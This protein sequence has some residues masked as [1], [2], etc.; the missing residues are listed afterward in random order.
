LPDPASDATPPTP[1]PPGDH[2]PS[3]AGAAGSG[4]FE[5]AG[6]IFFALRALPPA[7]RDHALA[8]LTAN[9][10]QLK[11]LVLLL[12]KGA[13][14]PLAVESLADD[15]RA[16]ADANAAATSGAPET[17][18]P[19]PGETAGDRI[20]PYRLLERLGEGGFGIVFAAEQL[21]PVRR[22]VAL[23]V[24]KLGM[25]TRQVVARFEAERQA[26]ALMDH[27]NIARVFDAGATPTGRP[28][29]A[30]ELVRGEPI[31]TFCDRE[32]L[33]LN[34][35]LAL[36]AA[37]CDAVQ[38][39]HAKGVIHRDIKPSNVLVS[40]SA[41]TPTPKVIDFGIAKATD[42]PLTEKTLFTEHRQLV[43]TPE[44]MS[45]EQAEGTR[46]IDTRTDVYALGVLLYELVT[47]VTPFDGRALRS[48]GYGEMQRIIREV[49]PPRPSTR[50]SQ[51]D[52]E[53]AA[54]AA[55]LRGTIPNRLRTLVKRELDWV[56]MKA[57]EKERARRYDSASNLA[58]DVRRHLAG[59][60]VLAVPPSPTYLLR[61]FVRRNKG[62]VAAAALLA[63]SLLAGLVGTA[64]GLVTA[65]AQRTEALIQR[66]RADDNATAAATERDHAQWLAYRANIAAALSALELGDR[67]RAASRLNACPQR[68]RG[69]EWRYA[70]ARLDLSTTLA[71]GIFAGLR[72]T[73]LEL[74]PDGA[75]L[76]VPHRDQGRNSF[77]VRLL[78]A[79]S[80]GPLVTIIGHAAAVSS[81]RFSPDGSRILTA[82]YDQT[83]RQWDAASGAPIGPVISTP[84]PVTSACWNADTSR[85]LIVA[86]HG[87]LLLADSATGS[88]IA[89]SHG[90]VAYSAEFLNEGRAIVTRGFFPPLVWDLNLHPIPHDLSVF[91]GTTRQSRYALPTRSGRAFA[92]ISPGEV[93]RIHRTDTGI[94]TAAMRGHWTG[95]DTLAFSRDDTILASGSQDNTLRTWDALSGDPLRTLLGHKGTVLAAA[96]SLDAARVFSIG[97]DGTLRAWRTDRTADGELITSP[98]GRQFTDLAYSPTSPLL[99]ITTGYA[100]TTLYSTLTHAPARQLGREPDAALRARFSSDGARLAQAHPD[101]SLS[102]WDPH[103]G[104]R[105]L[106]IPTLNDTCT[107]FAL[108]PDASRIAV[109]LWNGDVL[110]LN[111]RSGERVATLRRGGDYA[112]GLDF[113]SDSTTLFVAT[114]NQPLARFNAETGAPLAPLS[115]IDGGLNSLTNLGRGLGAANYHGELTVIFRLD[116]GE[117]LTTLRGHGHSVRAAAMHP[118]GSRV[119]TASFDGT[120]RVWDTSTGDEV[121]V[122]RTDRPYANGIS[123]SPDGATVG[124]VFEDA[125]AQFFHTRRFNPEN[126]STTTTPPPPGTP[127]ITGTPQSTPQ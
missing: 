117:T 53:P 28:Y 106:S 5:R 57:L 124:I 56:I 121:A 85:I 74:S 70:H 125:N 18:S 116:T 102:V 95:I 6:E 66:N 101:G 50:I 30:M 119:F 81:A 11:D 97:A 26:L 10:P 99:A 41:N 89:Q 25:D 40:L 27:P 49:S 35:R 19:R 38:H 42:R 87:H 20:G 46:D 4:R 94:E 1:R 7:E 115:R 2:P 93:I 33:P 77:G 24:L 31:T 64:T 54:A 17:R 96:F 8:P 126:T 60:A 39:A 72:A 23:K 34:Q 118:D 44:Y 113:S 9:D 76:L 22:T 29:F 108:S 78:D 63:L 107:A 79:A 75:R 98:G 73:P 127:S 84:A 13:D 62:P 61:T 83:V 80:A 67:D 88:T 69:W 14:A 21:E 55:K 47:G 105:L 92:S 51:S 37:V 43:G 111:A 100:P 48:A 109:A 114:S 59:Q 104:E 110:L 65:R 36:F 123:I 91:P 71:T 86:E 58:A 52:P 122:L 45:P 112:A 103:T 90:R 32:R 68:L 12:L 82:S 15:I 3:T 16:A 120:L